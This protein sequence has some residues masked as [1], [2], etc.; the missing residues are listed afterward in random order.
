MIET[1]PTRVAILDDDPSVR[2]AISRLLKASQLEVESF[3]SYLELL[4]YLERGRIDCLVLDLHMAGINGIEV[5]RYLGQRGI[6][7][8]TV[9]ITA[10]D[11]PGTRETCL[12]A[13]AVGYIRKPLDADAL[14]DAIHVAVVDTTH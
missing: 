13:G 12:L 2:T 9:V 14:L 7:L 8:P 11:A 10:H 6:A 3:A 1:A 5:M 4:N